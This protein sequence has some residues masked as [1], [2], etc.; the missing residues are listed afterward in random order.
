MSSFIVES[1]PQIDFVYFWLCHMAYEI[2]VPSQ[3]IEPV[4]P[5]FEEVLRTGSPGKPLLLLLASFL[6]QFSTDVCVDIFLDLFVN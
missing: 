1:F 2:L 5:V 6:L 4:L 3:G